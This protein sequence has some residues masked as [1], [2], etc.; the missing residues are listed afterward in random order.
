[1]ENTQLNIEKLELFLEDIIQKRFMMP[2][3]LMIGDCIEVRYDTDMEKYE[4]TLDRGNDFSGAR[5]WDDY[6]EIAQFMKNFYSSEIN[7]KYYNGVVKFYLEYTMQAYL[8][9]EVKRLK[10]NN[11]LN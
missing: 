9:H 8:D 3:S 10:E 2:K 5:F 11:T 6:G 1:M 7:E 4:A